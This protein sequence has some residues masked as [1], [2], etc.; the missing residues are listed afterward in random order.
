MKI[1]Q[2]PFNNLRLF[3]L[4]MKNLSPIRFQVEYNWLA[5]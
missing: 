5:P 3:G 4:S 2:S 1:V